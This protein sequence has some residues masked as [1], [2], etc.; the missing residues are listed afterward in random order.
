VSR[1]TRLTAMSKDLDG[2]YIHPGR[3]IHASKACSSLLFEKRIGDH[4]GR[5]A[6]S[7]VAG[8]ATKTSAGSSGKR[9]LQA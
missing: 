3:R 9:G 4:N 5:R 2:V 1:M 6:S 7:E 8:N